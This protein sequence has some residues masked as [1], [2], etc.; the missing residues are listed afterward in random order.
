MQR[1][2]RSW[3]IRA[4]DILK[5]IL[6]IE[7][8]T[9]DFSFN[10]FKKDQK[11][12]DAVLRNFEII[13]EAA[14]HIPNEISSKYKKAKWSEIIEMRNLIAHEYFGISLEIVWETVKKD[15]FSLKKFIETEIKGEQ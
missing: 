9:K 4:D 2:I 5:S 1:N 12:I 10:D 15:I 8:Y 6:L 14:K 13:G 11:T 3:K 7:S